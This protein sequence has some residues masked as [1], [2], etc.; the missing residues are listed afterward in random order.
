MSHGEIIHPKL[1]RMWT[2]PRAATYLQLS[3]SELKRRLN[4]PGEGFVSWQER[5]GSWQYVTVE[6]VEAALARRFP[7]DESGSPDQ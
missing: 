7:D 1:G 3:R 4:D 6:S 5:P 2:V